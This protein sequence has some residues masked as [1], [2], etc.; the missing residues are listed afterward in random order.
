M[1]REIGGN[2]NA[3]DRMSCL[4]SC[5][6]RIL[7][8]LGERKV[9]GLVEVGSG[10][11]PPLSCVLDRR[12]LNLG[13]AKNPP[14][15]LTLFCAVPSWQLPSIQ[16]KQFRVIPGRHAPIGRLS[17]SGEGAIDTRLRRK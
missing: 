16:L 1:V 5:S 6:L 15:H 14:P 10:Q 13:P 8:G 12:G 3:N 2:V 7:I 17:R 11:G 9:V 4:C